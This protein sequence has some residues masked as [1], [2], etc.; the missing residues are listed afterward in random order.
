MLGE[1]LRI[2]HDGGELM[3]H[4]VRNGAGHLSDG[5]QAFRIEQSLLG[6]PQVG[7]HSVECRC[8]FGNLVT[9]MGLQGIG[10]IPF[11]QG[12]H[13]R[14][15]VLQRASEAARNQE[16]QQ[17]FAEDRHQAHHHEKTV[18]AGQEACR[19]IVRLQDTQMD[20]QRSAGR[21]FQRGLQIT[22]VAQLDIAGI[23]F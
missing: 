4:V 19:F 16:N 3:A 2:R 6:L 10:K 17:S 1:K 11:F 18:Y 14:H 23:V 9:T 5:R 15:Q 22:L 8:H 7:A 13:A 12:P 20:F 21:E